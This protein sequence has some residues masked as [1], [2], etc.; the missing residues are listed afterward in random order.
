[1]DGKPWW[2]SKGMVAGLTGIIIGLVQIYC[3]YSGAEVDIEALS[4]T[5][6][7]ALQ[8]LLGVGSSV[9]G[10]MAVYGRL[11]ACLP[12]KKQ[13]LPKPLPWREKN[14]NQPKD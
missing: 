11:K 9:M 5:V 8:L 14:Y 10:L 2:V 7:N 12:I 4:G 1:M 13:V 6:A 3:G